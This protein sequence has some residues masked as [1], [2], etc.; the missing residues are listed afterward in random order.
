MKKP[1]IVLF[2]ADGMRCDSLACMGNQAAWTPY[3]DALVKEGVAFRNAYCQNPTVVPSRCSVMTGLYPHTAGHRTMHYLLRQ[4]EPNLLKIMKEAGYE[5][6]WAGKNDLIPADCDK[7]DY[8]D[9]WF[10]GV[11]DQDARKMNCHMNT[12]CKRMTVHW[13]DTDYSFFNGPPAGHEKTDEKCVESVLRYLDEIKKRNDD[14]PFFI[15]CSLSFPHVPYGVSQPWYSLID[16]DQL[17]ERKP[18]CHDK[19][20]MLVKTADRMNLH[21]WS[22]EDWDELRA[23]YLGMVAKWD[24]LLGKVVHKLKEHGFYDDTSIIA[25]SYHGDYTGDYDIVETLQNC[26]EDALSNVPLIIKPAAQ[27][28][29]KPRITDALVE[30]VDLYSTILEMSGIPVDHVQYGQSM[31]HVLAGDDIH[32]DAVFCEGGRPYGDTYAMETGH[33]NPLD[34]YWPRMSVQQMDDAH[35]RATMIRMGNLKYTMRMLGKDE[36]YDL[37]RDPGETVNQIDNPDYADQILRMKLRML[38]WYQQTADCIPSHKD[39][40]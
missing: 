13:S 26:F 40:R 29:V 20:D 8:C 34:P 14:K 22:Q 37:I 4:D 35:A 5:V 1:D 9:A 15:Y 39:K 16:R 31:M 30:L 17:L 28:S 21:G 33:E 38:E 3:M 27:F 24:S 7:S 19:P 23:V 12:I 18:W 25:C 10:D 11:H 2:T 6:I 36:L 32:K